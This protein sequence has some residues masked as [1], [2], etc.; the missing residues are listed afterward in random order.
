MEPTKEEKRLLDMGHEYALDMLELEDNM[1]WI[2]SHAKEINAVVKL[3]KQG[4]LKVLE[5]MKMEKMEKR[6]EALE[7]LVNEIIALPVMANVAQ[8]D[9]SMYVSRIKKF[10]ED[11]ESKLK[12]E[13][14][15]WEERQKLEADLI[16]YQSLV[17][18]AL[19]LM[20]RDNS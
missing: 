15:T 20:Q 8:K 12:D 18:P 1:P 2:K 9:P 5:V 4:K 14:V 17:S 11:T 19:P 6:V 13:N 10:I 7:K 16:K 3:M